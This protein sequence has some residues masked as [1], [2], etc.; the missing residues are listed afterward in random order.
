M[1]KIIDFIKKLIGFLLTK[2]IIIAFVI[3]G[4]YGLYNTF[5]ADPNFDYI[6]YARKMNTNWQGGVILIGWAIFLFV[7][8]NFKR[9]FL[10]GKMA[11]TVG[12][13]CNLEIHIRTDRH[14]GVIPIIEFYVNGIRYEFTSSRVFNYISIGKQLPVMYNKNDPSQAEIYHRPMRGLGVVLPLLLLGLHDIILDLFFL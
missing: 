2:G 13:V 9:W 14:D 6:E 3:L 11:I 10:K 1:E 8:A 4:V 12:Q 5:F 7:F